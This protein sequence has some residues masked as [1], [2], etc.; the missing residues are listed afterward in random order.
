MGKRYEAML[1]CRA[2]AEE[3]MVFRSTTCIGRRQFLLDTPDTY[4]T[5][6]PAVHGGFHVLIGTDVRCAARRA[7]CAAG[8]LLAAARRTVP[9]EASRPMLLP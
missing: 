5:Q 2:R 4:H 7:A 9:H 1:H 3:A 8:R 6:W